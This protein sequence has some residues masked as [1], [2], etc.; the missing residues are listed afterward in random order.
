[1]SSSLESDSIILVFLS[2]LLL[3]M[4]CWFS[5]RNSCGFLVFAASF[6]WSSMFCEVY[7]SSYFLFLSFGF[8]FGSESIP[9]FSQCLMMLYL[10]PVLF[11][12]GMVLRSSWF[13]SFCCVLVHGLYIGLVFPPLFLCFNRSLMVNTNGK[14]SVCM[15][16]L[17]CDS[18][19]V[20]EFLHLV[21]TST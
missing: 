8:D 21:L 3:F 2:S 18:M 4:N 10:F 15:F 12:Y 16:A 14:R 6:L 13:I 1:M 20:I 9:C 19:L 17:V 5:C 7:E 11:V